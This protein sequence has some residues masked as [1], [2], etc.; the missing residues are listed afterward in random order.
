MSSQANL[1]NVGR[2]YIIALLLFIAF[3]LG[4]CIVIELNMYTQCTCTL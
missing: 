4:N 2:T 3:G 1:L